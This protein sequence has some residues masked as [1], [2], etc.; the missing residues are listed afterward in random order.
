[1]E[2]QV[3][4]ILAHVDA[5]KTTLSEGI[6]Y[7][8]GNLKKL[9]RV[10][11]KDA[12]LDNYTLERERGIT[13]FSKQAVFEHDGV[14]F[15]LI[16]TPGHVDFSTE[17]ER[18]LVCLDLAVL[19]ISGPEGVQAHTRTLWKLLNVYDIPTF[20]FINKMDR[21]ERKREDILSELKTALSSECVPFDEELPLEDIALGDEALMEK[22]LETGSLNSDDIRQ[23]VTERKI[24]PVYFGSALRCEGIDSLL[25]GIAA[26]GPICVGREQFG[27]RVYKINRDK[28]GNRLT[29]LKVT[30]GSL[31]VRDLLLDEKITEIRVYNGERYTTVAEAFQGMVVAI[32]SLNGT[33]AGQALGC[34]E[35]GF[36]PELVPVMT[37]RVVGGNDKPGYTHVSIGVKDI[38]PCLKTMEEEDPSLRVFWNEEL[39]ELQISIMGDIQLEILKA[40]LFER[41]NINVLFDKG[42]ILYKETIGS[43]TVGVGHF[44]PLKHY[45]EV[46]LLMEPGERG[47]G[48]TFESKVSVNDLD[49][50]WQRLIE[51]HVFEREHKGVLTGAALTDVHMVL[52]AGR[53]HIKHTEGGDFRQATYRAIRQGLMK[54]ENILLEPYLEVTLELPLS[55]SG[56]A[57]TDIERM[58]GRI[59]S[60]EDKVL[61]ASQLSEAEVILTAIVPAATIAGYQNELIAYS[62]GLGSIYLSFYGYLPCHNTEEIV[63]QKAYDP[64]ADLRNPASSVFCAHGAGFVAEWY[65][66]DSYKHLEPDLSDE[67]KDESEFDD[68]K[69][70]EA[71]RRAIEGSVTGVLDRALSYTD[72]DEIIAQ[73]VSANRKTHIRKNPYRK[74][75]EEKIIRN[76]SLPSKVEVKNSKEKYLLVDGY[77]IIFAWEELSELAKCNIDAARDRLNEILSD[78]SGMHKQKVLVVYD[79]YRVRGHQTE[80]VRYHNISIIY[81]AEAETAD[82]FIERFT[83]ENAK[84]YDITVATSDGVEQIIIRGAGSKLLTASDLLGLVN[85]QRRDITERFLK[86]EP[87]ATTSLSDILKK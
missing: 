21:G 15:T 12:F 44:E 63:K 33:Y 14:S 62:K 74:Y 20:I 28:E 29:Y 2:R 24:F 9:G 38:L 70:E 17:M 13:I 78:Y 79:A 27:G 59:T 86:S 80:C 41:F 65:E 39:R 37:Y 32:P 22:Y 76:T 51:T 10:D 71:K 1:M 30:G 87:A 16:D 5:G 31:K 18:A 49:L 55:V 57:M 66:V 53:A 7:S 61:G 11:K 60:R 77:N 69:I 83:H 8:C 3:I 58:K 46:Q 84:Q 36:A 6:L 82:R 64:L 35:D 68:I 26:Y 40:G 45:A 72:V 75:R 67:K 52:V 34:E 54:A 23:L 85:L 56:R 81:T 4:G 50:N 47:S 43:K 48:I 19:V 25:D 42:S 73:S